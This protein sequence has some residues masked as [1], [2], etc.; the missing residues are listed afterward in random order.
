MEAFYQLSENIDYLSNMDTI[1]DIEK[2]YASKITTNL[3][4]M[5]VTH[6]YNDANTYLSIIKFY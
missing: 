4:C 3:I 1:F 6:T 2:V 5:V